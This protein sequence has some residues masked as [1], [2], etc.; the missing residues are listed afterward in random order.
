[1]DS[2][3][4]PGFIERLTSL[5]LREPEDR[6]Q[7]L[8]ILHS[9]YERNLMDADALTIIE[10]A[11]AASETRVTDVM[12]PRA[13]MDVIDI[14]DPLDDAAVRCFHDVARVVGVKTVAEFVDRPEVLA[15]LQAI[16]IDYAQGFLLHKPEPLGQLLRLGQAA[17]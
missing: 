6:E 9:A 11:L 1:M 5:L 4:K 10:G 17:T 15:R 13:Q 3:S 16:G 12:I 8:D 14:D 7:L 2:D